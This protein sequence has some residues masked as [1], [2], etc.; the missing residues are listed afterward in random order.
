MKNYRLAIKYASCNIELFFNG[1]L[2]YQ[3]MQYISIICTVSYPLFFILT[4]G[5]SYM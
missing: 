3:R 1:R 5:D 2:H 4:L